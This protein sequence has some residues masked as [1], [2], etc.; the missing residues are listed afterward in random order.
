MA[1]GLTEYDGSGD[2]IED[3]DYA[4]LVPTYRRFG[5]EG[6]TAGAAPKLDY[7]RC[8]YTDFGLNPDWSRPADMPIK[9]E[10]TEEELDEN[11][12]PFFFPPRSSQEVVFQTYAKKLK[13]LEDRPKVQGDYDTERGS[14]LVIILERCNPKERSTCKSDEDFTE[15]I[16]GKYVIVAENTW[17]FRSDT[18]TDKRLSA[19]AKLVWFPLSSTS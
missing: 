18:Y 8:N 13:C 14:H 4:T 7:R 12:P 10:Y 5:W 15:W 11:E 17:T 3:E 6:A 1:F 9:D 2:F 16:K 19:S